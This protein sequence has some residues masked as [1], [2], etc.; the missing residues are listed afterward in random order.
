MLFAPQ[1]EMFL[2]C[3][4][5]QVNHVPADRLTS[6]V[7]K[8]AGNGDGATGLAPIAWDPIAL[9][10]L[11]PQQTASL[12]MMSSPH[13]WSEPTVSWEYLYPPITL[14]GV[15]KQASGETAEHGVDT[16]SP[17]RASPP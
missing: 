16:A 8:P 11:E 9:R 7:R 10:V 14:S 3:I 6:F 4:N 17:P 15:T 13:T 2:S 1:Q 5:P 12:V